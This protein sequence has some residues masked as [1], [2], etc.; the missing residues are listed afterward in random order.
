MQCKF[1]LAS[2]VLLMQESSTCEQ[3]IIARFLHVGKTF[4]TKFSRIYMNR[5]TVPPWLTVITDVKSR[6]N[7]RLVKKEVHVNRNNK[8]P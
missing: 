3:C 4:T 5:N 1:T 2:G 6:T 7:G 8:Q